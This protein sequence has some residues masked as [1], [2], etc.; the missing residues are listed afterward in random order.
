MDF[1]KLQYFNGHILP[2]EIAIKEHILGYFFEIE[3]I[4]SRSFD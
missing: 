3:A 1:V 2:G 4:A